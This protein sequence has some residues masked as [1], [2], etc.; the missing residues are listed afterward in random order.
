MQRYSG[1]FQTKTR[2]LTKLPRPSPTA[3]YQLW[4]VS[5]ET[6]ARTLLWQHTGPPGQTLKITEDR[7]TLLYGSFGERSEISPVSILDLCR[8]RGLAPDI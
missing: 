5:S 4:Y 8:R 2:I 3:L 1:Q 6:G 7:A